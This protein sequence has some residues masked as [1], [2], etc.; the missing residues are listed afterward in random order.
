MKS[1]SIVLPC[2]EVRAPLL[3]RTLQSIVQQRYPGKL[4]IIVVEDVR[5]DNTFPT[6]AVKQVCAQYNAQ[7]YRYRRTELLPEFQSPGKIR[8]KGIHTATGEI[9]ITQDCEILHE[10]PH[11]IEDLVNFLGDNKKLLATACLRKLNERGQFSGWY[12]HPGPP[13]FGI[14]GGCTAAIYRETVLAMGG[15]EES[16]FGYGY[17]DN[18]YV[19]LLHKNG[20]RAEYVESA[21]TGHQWHLPCKGDPFTDAANRALTWGLGYEILWEGRPAIANSVAPSETTITESYDDVAKLVRAAHTIFHQG[22]YQQWANNWLLGK[23]ISDD[24]SFHA[25]NVASAARTLE[26]EKYARTGYIAMAAAEAAWAVR[27]AA[28]CYEESVKWRGKDLMWERRLLTCRKRHLV[29][30]SAAL[31]IGNRVLAGE[32]I[33]G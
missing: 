21:M 17:E 20:V 33:R 2:T 16:F 30:A 25:R 32:E 1:V 18:Y 29:L 28:K 22:E 8:N 7:C 27:W 24:A 3:D 11:V 19:W 4:E 31:R 23:N 26:P 12:N 15:F 6:S 9:L 5:A 14:M 10:S 13:K